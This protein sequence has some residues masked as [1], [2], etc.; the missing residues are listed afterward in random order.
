M[1]DAASEPQSDEVTRVE[2]D[3]DTVDA[4]LE[5]LDGDDLE[6]AES[7]VAALAGSSDPQG[8]DSADIVSPTEPD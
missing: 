5:A 1:H 4:V 3:L 7:L 8:G 2:V 6:A